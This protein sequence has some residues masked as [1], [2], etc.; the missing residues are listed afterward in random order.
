[1]QSDPIGLDDGPNTYT[2]VISNPL[3][4]FDPNGLGRRSN[5]WNAFQRSMSGSGLNSSQL[6]Q[7]YRQLG[8]NQI[9]EPSNRELRE[10]LEN[11]PDRTK[12][13]STGTCR[14][15]IT[16]CKCVDDGACLIEPQIK[17]LAENDP[18]CSCRTRYIYLN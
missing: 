17:P 4:Y 9:A 6:S 7:L 13:V 3:K 8:L 10:A 11:L 14:V 2:Y 5:P 12:C 16:E 18:L 1:M 15:E